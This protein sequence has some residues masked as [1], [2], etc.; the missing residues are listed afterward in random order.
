M[1]KLVSLDLHYIYENPKTL[2]LT[3]DKFLLKALEYSEAFADEKLKIKDQ[4][5]NMI[6]N[7]QID[8]ESLNNDF[9]S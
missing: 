4:K 2:V 8:Y 5:G 9:A 1:H 7:T 3:I 6:E